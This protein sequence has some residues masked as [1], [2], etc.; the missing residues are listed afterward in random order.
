MDSFQKVSHSSFSFFGFTFDDVLTDAEVMTT[1]S[2]ADRLNAAG[3]VKVGF[4][5]PGPGMVGADGKRCQH[6]ALGVIGLCRYYWS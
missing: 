3:L 4:L 1:C 6:N 5:A 2:A